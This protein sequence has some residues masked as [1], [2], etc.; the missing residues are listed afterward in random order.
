[1][2]E[3]TGER[4]VPWLRD[5][6]IACEHLHRYAWVSTMA[7]GKDVLDIACGEG[8]GTS[9]LAA[10]ARTAVGVDIDA[11]AVAHAAT[12]YQRPNLRY[13]AGAA[14]AIPIEKGASFDLVCCFEAIEHIEDQDGLLTEASRLLRTDGLF[15]VSTPNKTEYQGHSGEQNPFHVRELE[16]HEFEA[17]LRRHF[18]HVVLLGQRVAA[19]S[20]I[21]PLTDGAED[22]PSRFAIERASGGFE[23]RPGQLPVPLYFIAIASKSPL[24]ATPKASTLL[25]LSNALLEDR[26]AEVLE[27]HQSLQSKTE[28]LEW[29]EQQVRDCERGKEE[30]LAWMQE[31]IDQR[32]K[33][34]EW[35]ESRTKSLE[36]TIASNE[37][38]LTWRAT[39]V[40]FLEQEKSQLIELAQVRQ[41]L[42]L[43]A[44]RQLAV[45]HASRSWKFVLWLRRWKARFGG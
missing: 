37:E 33:S 30:A 12:K 1:M 44:Q 36:G 13:V 20:F 18:E 7:K 24:L 2:M 10:H 5:A 14:N 45:I 15:V 41:N 31:Q 23:F 32:D 4:F 8:Y 26:K 29:R 11:A 19:D 38:A 34:I 40:G 43:D 22:S 3:W 42:L 28:A 6:E 16:L 17:L 39:Q 27:L 21:W 9:M 25:D 35:L